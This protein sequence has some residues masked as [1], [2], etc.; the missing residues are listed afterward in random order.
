MRAY[1]SRIPYSLSSQG[2]NVFTPENI[3]MS[4]GYVVKT[5]SELSKKCAELSCANPD[6]LLFYRGQ[7]FDY[8]TSEN[9]T[10][11][12]SFYPSMYRGK[13][14]ARE[15]DLKWRKLDAATKLL[16]E[17]LIDKKIYGYARALRKNIVLWSILQHY[18]VTDTP[19][20]DVSQSLRVAC[21]FATLDTTAEFVYIYVLALPY[22][23]NRISVNSEQYL[24]NVRLISIVPPEALRPYHQ[25]GFLVG[26]DEFIREKPILKEELDFNRRLV[27]KF[28]IPNNEAFW[29]GETKLNIDVLYPQDDRV[30]EICKQVKL[31]AFEQLT[32]N[33]DPILYGKC[34]RT[35]AEIE[36]IMGDAFEKYF[37][38]PYM[39]GGSNLSMFFLN[40]VKLQNFF[41]NSR[42]LRNK[43]VHTPNEVHVDLHVFFDQL[44]DLRNQITEHVNLLGSIYSGDK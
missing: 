34:I 10:G 5:F 38:L 19:L 25:E 31:E 44:Q 12:S 7:C 27:Y 3:A 6:V 11:K 8:K 42:M 22:Y 18:E 29:A 14:D 23:T 16:R 15:L 36:Q 26:E 43:L 17:K 32:E 24:T 9:K 13:I 39:F 37:K 28:K 2:D 1:K 21:S 4:D 30:S 35:W 33:L 41:K 40:D 20:L